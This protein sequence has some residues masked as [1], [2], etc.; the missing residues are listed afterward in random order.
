MVGKMFERIKLMKKHILNIYRCISKHISAFYNNTPIRFF[1]VTTILINFFIE[2]VSRHSLWEA[3]VYVFTHP[4]IFLFNAS[5]IFLT[6]CIGFLFKRRDFYIIT[7]SVLW[8]TLGLVN[9]ILQFFRVTPLSTI[10]FFILPTAI[11]MLPVYLTPFEMVLIGL[12]VIAIISG[13]VFAW[14]KLPKTKV[15][16]KRTTALILCTVATVF[17]CTP[18]STSVAKKNKSFAV[19]TRAYD[20]WGFVYCFSRSIIDSGI[21]EPADYSK[22]TVNKALNKINEV[23]KYSEDVKPNLVI[24]QLESFFDVSSYLKD[25]TFSRNPIP[26]FTALKNMCPSGLLTMPSLGGGTANSEFEVLT[27]IN[28]DF[29]GLGEYPYQTILKKTPCESMARTLK[30]KGYTATAIHNHTAGFYK[31]NQVYP[32]LGFDKFVP[33]EYMD[34]KERNTL[35]WAKDTILLETIPEAMET[36]PGRD[37]IFT[38]TM[39]SHGKYPTEPIEG[40]KNIY[41]R[42]KHYDEDKEEFLYG[43]EYFANEIY[44]T[45]AVIAR[46]LEYFNSYPE[47]VAVVLYGDHLP[48]FD[49]HNEDL[50]GIDMY[51]TE[52]CIWTNY[53][54]LEN[55]DIDL[56]AYQLNAL[57]FDKLEL[58]GGIF[59]RI[60]QSLSDSENYSDVLE[61]FAYD[62]LYGERYALTKDFERANTQMGVLPITISDVSIREETALIHGERFTEYSVVLVNNEDVDTIYIDS[63]TLKIDLADLEGGNCNVS[64]A[65]IDDQNKILGQTPDFYVKKFLFSVDR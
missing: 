21:D 17:V 8:A 34:I 18:I 24:I 25:F 63:S 11:T 29:F 39:Q 47:P 61:L 37:F 41:V 50:N 19:L 49:I 13:F 38:V 22:Q 46:L 42:M 36:T 4:L 5:I 54:T 59:P 32:N 10:D 23:P 51:Q 52:Y 1:M 44:E 45:D 20:E 27:G 31:R 48:A 55:T 62:I 16:F 40:E 6:V 9:C 12:W 57:I 7:V 58:N 14:K 15:N 35:G 56:E 28:L 43:L 60:T 3:I 33:V 53:K 65:Q 30:E 26:T 64:V 2:S